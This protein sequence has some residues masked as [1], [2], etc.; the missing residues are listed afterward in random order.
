[1]E[2]TA[3]VRGLDHQRLFHTQLAQAWEQEFLM[4]LN[5][6]ASETKAASRAGAHVFTGVLRAGI[7]SRVDTRK[8]IAR[9]K[10]SAPHSWLVTFGRRSGKMP[11]VDPAHAQSPKSAQR[12]KDWAIAHG[13]EPFVLARSIARKGTK[14]HPFM[15]SIGE[16]RFRDRVRQAVERVAQRF[17]S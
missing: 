8:L 16:E 11:S 17:K 7:R 5:E 10:A 6:V 12:L 14:P 4:V 15:V 1:M 3:E 2:I 13:M 9:V